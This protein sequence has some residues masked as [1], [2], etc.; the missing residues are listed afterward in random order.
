[1]VIIIGLT[2]AKYIMVKS[3]C[4]DTVSA[5]VPLPSICIFALCTVLFVSGADHPSH[6]KTSD[7][8]NCLITEQLLAL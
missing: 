7:M 3:L 2:I 5:L 8:Q 4:L 1:M 6:H